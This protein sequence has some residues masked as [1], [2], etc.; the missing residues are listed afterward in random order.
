MP[1][2]TYTGRGDVETVRIPLASWQQILR[3]TRMLEALDQQRAVILSSLVETVEA[4][5]A[6][7]AGE[8]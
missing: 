1:D 7:E 8:T 6:D 3:R 5:P 2:E 4:T